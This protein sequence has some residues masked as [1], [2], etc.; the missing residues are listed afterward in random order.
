[1]ESGLIILLSILG[2]IVS[3]VF[4]IWGIRIALEK[5]RQYFKIQLRIVMKIAKKAGVTE[6]EIQQ[7]FKEENLKILN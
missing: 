5:E 4:F 1:M 7:L 3:F 2:F 6:A